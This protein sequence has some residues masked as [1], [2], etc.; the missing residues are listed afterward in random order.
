MENLATLWYT[1]SLFA[2][3]TLFILVACYEAHCATRNTIYDRRRRR[4][5]RHL[6]STVAGFNVKPVSPAPSYSKFAPPSYDSVTRKTQIF[7]IS[8]NCVN[9]SGSST[10]HRSNSLRNAVLIHQSVRT[11][12]PNRRLNEIEWDSNKK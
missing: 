8:E 2:L 11:A 5:E 12:D 6:Q 7:I 9:C 3:V 4:N 10:P 1:L